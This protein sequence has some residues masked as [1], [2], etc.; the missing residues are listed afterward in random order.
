[1]LLRLVNLLMNTEKLGSFSTD[2]TE[3]EL[4]SCNGGVVSRL[5]SGADDA[6]DATI[7]N[8][9]TTVNLTIDGTQD[10]VRLLTGPVVVFVQGAV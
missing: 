1:M 4:K 5:V 10:G 8:A 3:E 6:A 7:D 9:N 2:L